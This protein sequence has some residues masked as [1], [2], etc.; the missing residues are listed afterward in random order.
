MIN[1]EIARVLSMVRRARIETC[2]LQKK[3]ALDFFNGFFKSVAEGWSDYRL[4]AQ[5]V[6]G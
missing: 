1:D 4:I 2:K 6:L 5:E 3:D